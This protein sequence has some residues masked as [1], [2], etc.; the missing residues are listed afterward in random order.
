MTYAPG[1]FLD[2]LKSDEGIDCFHP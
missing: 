1:M 2:Y